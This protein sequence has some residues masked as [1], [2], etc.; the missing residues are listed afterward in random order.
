LF[1]K[2]VVVTPQHY[3]IRMFSPAMEL[4]IFKLQ[5]AV[6]Y[7]FK[8]KSFGMSWRYKRSFHARRD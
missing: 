3:D 2:K 4:G 1:L 7:D 5:F 8:K 6:S